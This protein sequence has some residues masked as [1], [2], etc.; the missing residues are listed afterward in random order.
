MDY[1]LRNPPAHMEGKIKDFFA[2]K[3]IV[4]M[5]K[6][7]KSE[8]DVDIKPMIYQLWAEN[9]EIFM[10]LAAGSA[11]NLKPELVM[12]AFEGYLGREW[13]AFAFE[14]NRV[15]IYADLETDPGR[16]F[17]SLEDLGEDIGA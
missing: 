4:I 15:E 17:I 2:Q 16:K 3:S 12:E 13:N 10:Q 11:N 14:V 8:Q 1:D 9:G 5:K 7:K 6:T